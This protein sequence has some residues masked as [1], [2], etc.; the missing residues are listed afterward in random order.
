VENVVPTKTRVSTASRPPGRN[1]ATGA[2]KPGRPRRPRGQIATVHGAGE[3]AL[4]EGSFGGNFD[5]RQ[6]TW[7]DEWGR[8]H[9]LGE[10]PDQ[11]ENPGREGN[12]AEEEE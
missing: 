9:G 2:A 7:T 5:P 11:P 6:L 10:R 4:E 12:G 1:R 3:S 8:L